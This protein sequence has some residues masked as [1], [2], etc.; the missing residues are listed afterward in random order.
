MSTGEY[1]TGLTKKELEDIMHPKIG[2]A[3]DPS[4]RR[5]A[6]RSEYSCPNAFENWVMFIRTDWLKQYALPG[7]ADYSHATHIAAMREAI[8]LQRDRLVDRVQKSLTGRMTGAHIQECESMFE[9]AMEFLCQRNPWVR[10][11]YRS[12]QKKKPQSGL[13]LVHSRD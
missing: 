7:E 11:A 6:L 2:K 5:K 4:A 8:D 13:H 12:V 10:E 3:S 1:G 9:A